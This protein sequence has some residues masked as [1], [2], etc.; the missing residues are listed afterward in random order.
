MLRMRGSKFHNDGKRYVYWF[1]LCC[2]GGR[3]QTDICCLFVCNHYHY[4]CNHT[5]DWTIRFENFVIVM[6]TIIIIIISCYCCQVARAHCRTG[7]G[8]A[9]VDIA[10]YWWIW[11]A[12]IFLSSWSYNNKEKIGLLLTMT[13]VSTICE[14]VFFIARVSCISSVVRIK[15]IIDLIGP[16]NCV[17]NGHLSVLINLYEYDN[18]YGSTTAAKISALFRNG[19]E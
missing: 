13:D 6:I 16:L 17:V 8:Y 10:R 2:A 4:F 5:S 15:L 19:L 7:T 3:K 12:L 1:E 9:A 11:I 18:N 14:V